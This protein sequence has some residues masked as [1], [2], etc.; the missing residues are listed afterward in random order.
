[1]PMLSRLGPDIATRYLS[2]I[3]E[4]FF[5]TADSSTFGLIN[6]VTSVARDTRDPAAR[7][8]LEELGGGMLAE[9]T[10]TPSQ[11]SG[12]AA[13]VGRLIETVA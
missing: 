8:R 4:R 6:A 2:E 12:R 5:K 10:T 11:D 13:Q 7:W 1:M 9:I 3:V